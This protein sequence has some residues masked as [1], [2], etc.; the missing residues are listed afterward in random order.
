[1]LAPFAQTTSGEIINENDYKRDSCFESFKETY[2]LSCS[3]VCCIILNINEFK[4]A[5][6]DG[7]E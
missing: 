5:V 2:L 7:I 3:P 4:R 6:G 1:M